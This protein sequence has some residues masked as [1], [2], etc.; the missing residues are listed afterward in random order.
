VVI[1]L[2]NLSFSSKRI[3]SSVENGI[4]ANYAVQNIGVR[5]F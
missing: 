3:Q 5:T 4:Q 1:F 2:E